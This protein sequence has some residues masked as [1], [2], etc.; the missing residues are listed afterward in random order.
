MHS[1]INEGGGYIKIFKPDYDYYQSL[2]CLE[3]ISILC[4]HKI[5]LP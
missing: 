1:I 3:N 2:K 5:R 4:R